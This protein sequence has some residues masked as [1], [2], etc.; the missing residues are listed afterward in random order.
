MQWSFSRIESFDSCPYKWM[1]RYIRGWDEKDTF[2]ASYGTFIHEIIRKYYEG[3]LNKHQ[4]LPYYLTN[5]KVCVLGERPKDSTVKKYIESGVNYFKNFQPFPYNIIAVEKKVNFDLDGI[6]FVGFIDYIGEKDNDYII[7]D[8]KSRELKQRSG[9][10][11]PTVKDIE[12][13]EMLKQ[14]YIY[15]EA[16]FQLFGKYPKTLAFNCFRNGVFIEEQF[17]EN[18][19]K[20]AK[21][22]AVETIHRI[23]DEE[24]FA[25]NQDMFAC[26]W[27]CGL[28]DRCKYDIDAKEEWRRMK[29]HEG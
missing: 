6:P 1:L 24:D 18:A 16:I 23:E 4:L 3:E 7:V 25:P 15:S 17:D 12:L 13:D 20:N 14:L 21:K 10:Q 28:S 8:N 2:Y 22:W 26:K 5:F 19:F 11:K 29:L 9:R 27:L